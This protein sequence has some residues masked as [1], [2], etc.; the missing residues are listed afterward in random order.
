MKNT[1]KQYRQW[2]LE[3]KQNIS[4]SK[5][6]TTLQVNQN[7]LV[8]YWYI[9]KQIIQK[10]DNEKW[11]AKTI[12]QLSVDL[13][14]GFTDLQGFSVRN[15]LYMKQFAEAYPDFLIT[16]QL[17]AQL[18][19]SRKKT[20]QQQIN[21]PKTRKNYNADSTINAENAITQ[22]AAAQF[23]NM[24]WFFSN[25]R[26]ASIPWGHHIYLLDKITDGNERNWYIH[27]TIENNWSRAVLRYQVDT[28]LYER[29]VKAKKM[30]NFHLTLPKAQGD[31]A[32]QILEDPYKFGFI[33]LGEDITEFELEQQII[34]HIEEFLIELG[35]GFA[36]VGRQVALKV[37]RRNRKIDLLFYHLLLR[38]FIVIDLKMDEFEW[39]DTGQM[40]GYLNVIN[41][42]FRQSTDNPTIGIILCGAKD[43]IDVDYALQN[44]NH[45]IGVSEYQYIKS[46]PAL[47]KEKL[48]TAKQLKDEV[49]K[50]VN[51]RTKQ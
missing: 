25:H 8:L 42:N 30:S 31:L 32:N 9:G 13:Q 4:Q 11:G 5:L 7:M 19:Q 51:R 21:K 15:L 46:L 23:N 41:K 35:A 48:P 29:Q 33:Q 34:R 50:I 3:L 6:Q 14:K 49:K 40:N 17:A 36:F 26:L 47:L 44:I 2:L 22:Q 27:K 28:D 12:S 37:G 18:K 16:Q 38:S 43:N 24:Q 1:V 10:I 45:P 20:G 39:E